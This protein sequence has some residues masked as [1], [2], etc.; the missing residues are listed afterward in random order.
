MRT[1]GEHLR[2]LRKQLGLSQEAMAA[3]LGYKRQGN[4]S[5]Y[6]ADKKTPSVKTVL[7][8]AAVAGQ[9]PSEFLADVIVT[10]Y[11]R[12]RAGMYDDAVQHTAVSGERTRPRPVATA[13]RA[14]MTR[15]DPHTGRD[16]EGRDRGADGEI[17]PVSGVSRAE[18][19]RASAEFERLTRAAERAAGIPSPARS[20][21]QHAATPR[22]RPADRRAAARKHRR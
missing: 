18:I 13:A 17:D 16:L 19:Q 15:T 2:A 22:A 4:L 9:L 11:D 10:E 5:L 20:P 21:R 7:R 3:R 1:Y 8:H 6:E 14:G 12:I